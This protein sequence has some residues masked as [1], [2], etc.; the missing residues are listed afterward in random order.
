MATAGYEIQ[1]SGILVRGHCASIGVKAMD[2]IVR[3]RFLKSCV[4]VA[5]VDLMS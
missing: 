4:A 1:V 5:K 2:G 3:S